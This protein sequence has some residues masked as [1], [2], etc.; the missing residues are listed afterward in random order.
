MVFCWALQP[1][2]NFPNWTWKKK[3]KFEGF[4]LWL[5]Q[6]NL[7]RELPSYIKVCLLWILDIQGSCCFPWGRVKNVCW[8]VEVVA[9]TKSHVKKSATVH[10]QVLWN[11][12]MCLP[13]FHRHTTSATSWCIVTFRSYNWQQPFLTACL[14]HTTRGS[15]CLSNMHFPSPCVFS[16]LI[17]FLALNNTP[18]SGWTPIYVSITCWR[19]CWLRP[20]FSS[21][22]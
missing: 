13:W 4:L 22:A 11:P 1:M 9:S 8:M 3:T 2:W 17:P 14:S 12:Y 21:D 18:L 7:V 19:T 6:Y 5:L 20:S 15:P 16:W 10:S